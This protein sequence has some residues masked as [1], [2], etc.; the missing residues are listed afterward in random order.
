MRASSGDGVPVFLLLE[1]GTEGREDA[2]AAPCQFGCD[3]TPDIPQVFS[4]ELSPPPMRIATMV[5]YSM[6][7]TQR[8][9]DDAC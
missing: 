1:R 4:P 8:R 6:V 5:C 3:A 2:S 7:A 9:G